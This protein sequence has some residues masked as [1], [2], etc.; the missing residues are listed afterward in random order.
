MDIRFYHLTRQSIEQALPAL[1]T[2]ALQTQKP[3][4]IKTT[5]AAQTKHLDDALWT[6]TPGSFL[7]HSTAQDENAA[8]QPIII[9][10]QDE[11]PN[12]AKILILTDGATA[13]SVKDYDLCC[14]IFDGRNS[15]ATAKAR[16][17]WKDYKNDEEITLT[18]WQ[19]NEQGQW[20]QKS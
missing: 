4:L 9:T 20:E 5:G 3:I 12:K 19:Q 11:N 18:Y 14:E 16:A 17:K 2:K 15:E 10:D 1:L 6:Q 7:P 8:R 13:K